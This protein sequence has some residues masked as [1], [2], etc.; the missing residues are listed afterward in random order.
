M[1][2]FLR[3]AHIPASGTC[4]TVRCVDCCCCCSSYMCVCNITSLQK[5]D[6]PRKCV[7]TV[8]IQG[9]QYDIEREQQALSSWRDFQTTC[10]LSWYTTKTHNKPD[11]GSST[12]NLHPLFRINPIN[13]A[14]DTTPP[15]HPTV[16]CSM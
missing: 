2:N 14:L 10:T 8:K 1:N 15:P 7:Y 12:I 9:F 11:R 5:G 6:Y 16:T 3:I 13:Y 4:T